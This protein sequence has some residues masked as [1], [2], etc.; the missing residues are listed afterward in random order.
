VPETTVEVHVRIG[1]EELHAGTLWAHR[2]GPTESATFR[3]STAY[4]ANPDGYALDPTLPLYDQPL[5][6]AAGRAMFGAFT[7]CAPDRWGR[8]LI[9]RDERHRVEVEGGAARSF[10]EIDYLLRARDDMRQG[11]VRFRDPEDGIYLAPSGVPSFLELSE[12]LTAAEHLER[13]EASIEEVRV[14]LRGGSSLGGARPKA[15]VRTPSGDLGIAKF[16]SPA[17]DEWSVT[18]WE[19]VALELAARA[20]ITVPASNLEVL[21]GKAVLIVRRFDRDG[22][23][24]VGYVSA[25]TMLQAAD[26]DHG[27]YVEI[28]DA[29][30][31]Q[32][33]DATADR[34]ELWRRAAFAV[35]ISNTDNHLRN[36]GFLRTSTAG[37]R[38]SPAFDLNPDPQ[39]GTRYLSTGIEPGVFAA[40]IEPLIAASPWFDLDERDAIEILH[41]VVD[42]TGDWREVA[43]D[44]EL[45]KDEIALMTSAF[46]HE[47]A[48]I[49]RSATLR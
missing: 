19:A 4:L 16:P 28:A 6:T 43:R 21:D 48:E 25:M 12:L 45:S 15:H 17:T 24:R 42:A 7:D 13:G 5:Q 37:W 44:F 14:L 9:A 47:Q 35:L 32:S 8:R 22:D 49:A 40:E 33:A 11:A 34:R 1:E 2:R 20:G 41:Q 18:R 30:G 39:L 23:V 27:S 29:I 38:L 46:E 3:Y 36:H 26:G 10:G 31:E